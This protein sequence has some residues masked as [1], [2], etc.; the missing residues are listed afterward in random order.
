MTV[1]VDRLRALLDAA[2]VAEGLEL[3][4][5]LWALNNAAADALPALLGVV[6]ERDRLAATVARVRQASEDF[7]SLMDQKVIRMALE[8][9]S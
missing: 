1:D 7:L 3:G 4:K 2:K 9:E 5:A 6:A 8:D